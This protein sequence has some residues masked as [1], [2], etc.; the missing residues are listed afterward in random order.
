MKTPNHLGRML[1]G[2]ASCATLATVLVAC[3]GRLAAAEPESPKPTPGTAQPTAKTEKIDKLIRQL[4]DKDYY[5]RQRAQDELARLGFDAFEAL[6]AATTDPDPEIASRAKYLLR[7]TRMEWTT[8]NDPP[9]VKRCL[10]DYESL[11]VRVRQ[12]RML[13]LAAMPGGKGTA[14]LC[15][16]VR[17]E[18]SSLLSKAAAIALLTQDRDQTP[19]AGQVETIRKTLR[20]CK[21]TAAT[22]LLCWARLGSEPEAAMAQWATL[23]DAEANV[24]ARHRDESGPEI[25]SGLTRF[26]IALLKKMGK[27]EQATAAIRR[28]VSLEQGN[29]ET[30]TELLSW[31]IEQKAW[32]GVDVLAG[33]FPTRFAT[34]PN[35][36]YMLA[37]A[38]AEQGKKDRAEATASSALRL[39]PD[40]DETAQRHHLVQAELLQAR[41]R[42]AWARREYDALLTKTQAKPNEYTAA[43]WRRLGIMLHDQG[44]DLEAAK[45]LGKLIGAIEAGKINEDQLLGE[46]P[47]DVRAQM[48]FYSACH[49]NAQK[50]TARQRESL[51]KAIE[52]NPEDIDVLIACYRL[53]DQPAEYRA[54]IVDAIRRTAVTL[55]EAIADDPE[56]ADNYNN[57]AWLIG[58]TE[59]DQDEAL[60][61]A[62]KAV[63]LE[64][65]RGGYFDTLGHV[66]AG[67]GDWENAVKA[68]SQAAKLD[69]H[70]GLIRRAL[71]QY[72]K[73][74]DEHKKPA[75]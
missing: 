52:A 11:D 58:N 40:K 70:S 42:F 21:R 20:D 13:S 4:G 67:R 3:T 74:L 29:A 26:Q 35:L 44:D 47:K 10:R 61:D 51:D 31:L 75:K 43:A 34:E 8:E 68:Q 63:E 32:K 72:R 69:P 28:L 17:F 1:G 62:Q 36:L 45:T 37:E 54:S 22:W 57:Y 59:G 56:S 12:V 39:L 66:Y 38:Y 5:V 49:W 65:D 60:R 64:P 6:S 9:E 53:P 14:A 2:F 71:E 23:V 50:N 33:R 15:R 46:K 25:V 27:S 41:G 18:K 24:L 48:F 7:L 16:L 30:L 19:D 55:R 73:K